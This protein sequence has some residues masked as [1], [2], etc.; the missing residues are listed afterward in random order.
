MK[1]V[2]P[3]ILC[4]FSVAFAC[5]IKPGFIAHG[6]IRDTVKMEPICAL[7]DTMRR[8]IE[9]AKW[10]EVWGT[11]NDQAGKLKIASVMSALEL[12]GFRLVTTRTTEKGKWFGYISTDETIVLLTGVNDPLI[13]L[14]ISGK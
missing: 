9:G 12:K 1:K 13:F 11:T 3:L 8:Q 6:L 4:L 10:T 14:A 7:G 2:L 5:D